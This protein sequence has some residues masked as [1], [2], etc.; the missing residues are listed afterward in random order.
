MDL[1]VS[2]CTYKRREIYV[3]N[4]AAAG[5]EKKGNNQWQKNLE[6]GKRKSGTQLLWRES[7][8]FFRL[9]YS[10]MQYSAGQERR[11]EKKN[12]WGTYSLFTQSNESRHRPRKWTI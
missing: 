2:V 5:R 8:M 12:S 10:L 4:S 6:L 11:G 9:L 1:C 7:F 3:T